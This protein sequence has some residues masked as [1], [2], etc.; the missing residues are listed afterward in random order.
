VPRHPRPLLP[1]VLPPVLLPLPVRALA[2]TYA[3]SLRPSSPR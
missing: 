3:C 2:A 1:P